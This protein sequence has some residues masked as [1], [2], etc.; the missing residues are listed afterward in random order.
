MRTGQANPL[1]LVSVAVLLSTVA[2]GCSRLKVDVSVYIGP[3]VDPPNAR[4]AWAV[5]LARSIRDVA[6][7]T[8]RAPSETK[9]FSVQRVAEDHQ[10]LLQNLIA[11]YGD[12][13]VEERFKNGEFPKDP[14]DPQRDA[15]L[16]ALL[17][18]GNYAQ[19]IAQ[20]IGYP[21][22]LRNHF[23][24]WVIP[25]PRTNDEF[26]GVLVM[27]DETGKILRG[28]ADSVLADIVRS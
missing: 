1:R 25:Y 21:I 4:I 11:Y 24:E 14:T 6:A 7:D 8:C 16:Q 26:V 9:L 20:R 18:Y 15:L 27:I 13:R 5:G 23:T 19:A 28:L 10:A 3:M 17:A 12:L 22:L 2:S